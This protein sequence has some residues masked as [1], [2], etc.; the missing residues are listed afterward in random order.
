MYRVLNKGP[1]WYR[2]ELGKMWWCFFTF[3]KNHYYQKQSCEFLIIW[4]G[5][6]DTI[7]GEIQLITSLCYPKANQRSLSSVQ[8]KWI[9][10]NNPLLT[11]HGPRKLGCFILG[12]EV[13][14]DM[15]METH[16]QSRYLFNQVKFEL[17]SSNWIQYFKIMK[18]L[19]FIVIQLKCI[20]FVW[21]SVCEHT[22]L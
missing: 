16:T 9:H 17:D 3:F 4:S 13:C 12:N 22:L 2:V 7:Q 19:S 18:Q 8:P 6:V 14:R 11:Q 10:Q 5:K 21:L 1:Y 15:Y 20:F